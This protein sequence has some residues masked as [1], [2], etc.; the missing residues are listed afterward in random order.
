[1]RRQY[2]L[3]HVSS[4]GL[5]SYERPTQAQME[6][7]DLVILQR[8][9]NGRHGVEVAHFRHRNGSHRAPEHRGADVK[10]R[11]SAAWKS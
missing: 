8:E 6:S 2:E 5:F 4:V 11:T 7:D 9:G 1:L 3:G 10:V